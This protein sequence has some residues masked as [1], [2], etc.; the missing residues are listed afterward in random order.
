MPA[1]SK[2]TV[3][4]KNKGR[5]HIYV[6]RGQGD[7]YALTVSEDIFVKWSFSKGMELSED[8]IVKIREE[9]VLDKAFQKT[10]NYLSY[11]MRSEKEVLQYMKDQEVGEEEARRLL[12]RLQDLNLLDD[13]AFAEAFVRT[14]KNTQKKGP[15]LIEQEL[16]QKGISQKDIDHALKE[17][18]EEEELE[19]AIKTASKKQTSYKKEGNRQRKQKLLQFLMQRGF[20]NGIAKQA[21]DKCEAEIP[22][23]FEWEGLV[24]QGEKA[25][26][27][28]QKYEAWER[29]QR[30][31]QY[32]Y[33][34]GFSG[35]SIEAWFSKMKEE[36]SLAEDE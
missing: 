35:D 6:D 16:Y 12:D 13:R 10:L 30:I 29:D 21:V 3:A 27:K 14:K 33:Q 34:R 25:I 23:D 22:E 26:K 19:N 20:S 32:L 7:E 31:K 8:D 28:F 5:F 11:R 4:K 36:G 24:K 2:I 15:L 17:Y 18:P 9:D 1:I